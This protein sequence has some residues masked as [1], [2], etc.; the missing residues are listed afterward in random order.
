MP[1]RETVTCQGF[2][3]GMQYFDTAQLISNEQLRI[4]DDTVLTPGQTDQDRAAGLNAVGLR[5][6]APETITH[7]SEADVMSQCESGKL[8][9]QRLVNFWPQEQR[10]FRGRV[11]ECTGSRAEANIQYRIRYD[12]GDELWEIASDAAKTGVVKLPTSDSIEIDQV[13][14]PAASEPPA[15]AAT[16]A[17][18]TAD[19]PPTITSG[20]QLS[21]GTHI[22]YRCAMKE[23]IFWCPATLVS[24]TPGW[25]GWW[26][27]CIAHEEA[28]RYNEEESNAGKAIPCLNAKTALDAMDTTA[29]RNQTE[30]LVRPGTM[31]WMWRPLIITPG[32]RI[33]PACRGGSSNI[34]RSANRFSGLASPPPPWPDTSNDLFQGLAASGASSS[35]EISADTSMQDLVYRAGQC[36]RVRASVGDDTAVQTDALVRVVSAQGRMVECRW[37]R[38]GTETSLGDA[39][40]KAHGSAGELFLCRQKH[41]L[42]AELLCSTPQH[43]RFSTAPPQAGGSEYFCWRDFDQGTSSRGPSFT[44]LTSDECQVTAVAARASPSQS[45]SGSGA[46]F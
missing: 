7:L 44:A 11:V 29:D 23:S 24:Q 19:V 21:A 28:V 30:L 41:M 39:W 8:V 12:D 34:A 35:G 43:V 31:G 15:M 40:D 13:A 22:W 9:G 32:S 27:A 18:G 33:T 36:F 2:D 10:W 5:P 45:A 3:T 25:P 17:E 1:S 37:L 26:V 14:E 42:P 4:V 38:R 16:A 20:F 46:L 6:A